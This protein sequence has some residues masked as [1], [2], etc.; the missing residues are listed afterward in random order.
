MDRA[1]YL[2]EA[3]RLI[4]EGDSDSARFILSAVHNDDM[5]R[6]PSPLSPPMPDWLWKIVEEK[7]C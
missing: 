5:Y 1:K 7:L 4:A 2:E 6:Q 3:D